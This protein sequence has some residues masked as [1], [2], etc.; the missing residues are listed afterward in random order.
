M[1][2]REHFARDAVEEEAKGLQ[3]VGVGK[4]MSR[5]M[6]YYHK[7][8]YRINAEARARRAGERKEKGLPPIEAETRSI[9]H[10]GYVIIKHPITGKHGC[11]EHRWVMEEYLERP[12]L[13]SEAVHHINGIKHDNRLEN[14]Q[15]MTRSEHSILHNNGT[16]KGE[17]HPRAKLTDKQASEIK[18]SNKNAAF[19]AKK[20]NVCVD[21]IKGIKSGKRWK[22]IE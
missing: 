11:R 7:N 1:K 22:H 19:L 13:S 15:L 5:S 12:L 4:K 10:Y 8:K 20:Y 2:N 3:P 9:S 14:L 6:K 16:N 18:H 17:K 21:T